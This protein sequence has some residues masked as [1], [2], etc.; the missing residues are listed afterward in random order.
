M[1][2]KGLIFFEVKMSAEGFKWLVKYF[3]AVTEVEDFS[4]S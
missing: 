4:S 1:R 2:I 3:E